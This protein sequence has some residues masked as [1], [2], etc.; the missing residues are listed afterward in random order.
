MKKSSVLSIPLVLAL[1]FSC[2]TPQQTT[3]SNPSGSK[4]SGT[5]SNGSKLSQTQQADVMYIF[6]NASKEKMLGN[7]DMAEN[8]FSQVLRQD[9]NNHAAMYNLADIYNDQKKYTDA[10]Y[11]AKKAYTLDSKNEWYAR[12]LVEIYE[13]NKKYS[14]AI[15]VYQKLTKDYPDRVDL[16]FGLAEE[17]I[18]DDKGQDAIKTYDQIESKMGVSAEVSLQKERLYVKLGKNDKA[19]AEV[20]KLIDSDPD[21]PRYLSSL[22]SLYQA[23]G[24]DEKAFSLFNKILAT[25]PDDPY[26]HLSLADYYRNKGEKDKSY[27]ELKKAFTNKELDTETKINILSSY[28]P[29]VAV[30][31]EMKSQAMELG[32]LLSESSPNEARVHAVYGDF[33]SQDKKYEEARKEYKEALRIGSKEFAVY[34]QI[35]FMDSQLNDT[36]ASLHDSEDALS[37]FPEQPLAYYFNGATKVQMKKYD[38]AVATLNSGLK[39]VVDNKA[40]EGQFYSALGD[41]YNYI[42]D[43][44][45][46]D[47]NYQKALNLDPK[48]KYV[49]NNWAYYLSLRGEKLDKAEEMSKKSMELEPNSAIFEDTYA[50]IVYKM[51]RFTDAKEWME[52][53]FSHGA[54]K[55]AASLEHYGDILFKLGD[56]DKALE[57]WLKAKKAGDGTTDL[58]DKKIANKKLYEAN[59]VNNWRILIIILIHYP[60]SIIH[61]PFF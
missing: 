18:Y 1:F 20:Q 16:Y 7:L 22:A 17:Y 2:K 27:D 56:P 48:D 23:I 40:L 51:G 25:H 37:K 59:G 24:Q 14:D 12:L 60:L 38:A 61:Y 11:F 52:K 45:K 47:E 5:Q 3:K 57:Y 46:S 55:S 43:Y 44:S 53:A 4:N 6:Y 33:L 29:L 35:L 19:I 49:M 9:I 26:V 50:W 10:L 39:L 34:Q 28:F 41:A 8:L 31:E 30:N 15:L 13:R 21:N 36:T 42:K 32:K 58:L 54:D